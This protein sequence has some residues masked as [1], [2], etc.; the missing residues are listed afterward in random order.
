MPARPE[1]PMLTGRKIEFPFP[2]LP[3][4]QAGQGSAFSGTTAGCAGQAVPGPG[5]DGSFCVAAG[6]AGWPVLTSSRQSRKGK[7]DFFFE[8]ALD[9][10]D[11]IVYN[12]PCYPKTAGFRKSRW[13]SC[14][15]Q[16]V[17]SCGA[18]CTDPIGVFLRAVLRPAEKDFF[19]P[20]TIGR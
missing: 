18:V 16:T 2:S 11:F 1:S 15:G 8:K 14:R 12:N 17:L 10:G 7:I 13:L 4:N 20:F 6:G 19:I 3:G 9:T 5:T